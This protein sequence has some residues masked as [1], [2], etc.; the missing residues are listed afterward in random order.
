MK[1]DY[2]PGIHLLLDFW[3]AQNLSDP[4][5]IKEALM[6]AAGHCSAT[7]LGCHI[8]SFG[9]NSGV[10]GVV[11]LAESHMTIHTWPDVSYAAIDVF[12]CGQCDAT[13]AIEPLRSLFAPTHVQIKKIQRGVLEENQPT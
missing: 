11:M 2:A 3:G 12:M 8:H 9:E 1:T 10:T 6:T 5:F 13:R 7:V 4:N